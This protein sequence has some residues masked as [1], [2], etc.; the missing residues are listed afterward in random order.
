MRELTRDGELSPS[1][2]KLESLYPNG[3]LSYDMRYLKDGGLVD[4]L[5]VDVGL[6][7]PGARRDSHYP[8]GVGD[9]AVSWLDVG[10]EQLERL[11]VPVRTA[12]LAPDL[13]DVGLQSVTLPSTANYL[14]TI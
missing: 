4:P 12:P 6:G 8:L 5:S 7:V 1:I 3:L 14:A 2:L 11:P 10:S 13:R 9:D